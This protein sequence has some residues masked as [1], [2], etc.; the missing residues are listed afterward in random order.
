M[1]IYRVLLREWRNNYYNGNTKPNLT[2]LKRRIYTG[3]LPGSNASG[4]YIVY[5]DAHHE[6]THPPQT[7]KPKL[8]GNPI[9]DQIIQR[10]RNRN[11]Q[12]AEA[13]P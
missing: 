6:P 11:R 5:C 3:I 4:D 10:T 12:L 8:T 13:E 9:A 1:T 2:E 7:I